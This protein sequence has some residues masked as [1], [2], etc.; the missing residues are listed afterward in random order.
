MVLPTEFVAMIVWLV[1]PW[2]GRG[3]ARLWRLKASAAQSLVTQG[4]R[5]KC[6]TG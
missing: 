3:V 6:G 4:Q 2:L 1:A 5:G